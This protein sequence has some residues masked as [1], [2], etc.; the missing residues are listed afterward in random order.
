MTQR[1]CNLNMFR[2]FHGTSNFVMRKCD[3]S[4]KRELQVTDQLIWEMQRQALEMRIQSLECE[5]GKLNKKVNELNAMAMP[6]KSQIIVRP[7][8]V[9]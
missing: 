6:V 1:I 2:R 5:I 7:G 4:T 3:Q 9:G 8:K